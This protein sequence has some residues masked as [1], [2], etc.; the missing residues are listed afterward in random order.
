[1]RAGSRMTSDE[2]LIEDYA[3]TGNREALDQVVKRRWEEAYRL[4]FRLLFDP[5][6]AEDVDSRVKIETLSTT[7]RLLSDTTEFLDRD[8]FFG[9][10]F[11]DA[12]EDRRSRLNGVVDKHR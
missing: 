7:V 6:A 1:M 10:W 5:G 9:C 12:I 4:S 3:L 8:R 2:S 11:H